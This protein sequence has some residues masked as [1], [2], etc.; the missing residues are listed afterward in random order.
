[1]HHA[2]RKHKLQSADAPLG[3]L[4]HATAEPKTEAAP[5]GNGSRLG[6]AGCKLRAY[7]VGISICEKPMVFTERRVGVRGGNQDGPFVNVVS[8][9]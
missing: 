4:G 7:C 9:V 5:G 8:K 1:M 6:D 2:R 3:A